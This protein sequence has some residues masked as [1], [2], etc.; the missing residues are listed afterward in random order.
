MAELLKKGGENLWRRIH[1]LIKLI[2]TRYQMP[3]EW[4]TGIIQPIYEKR[5][6]L[7]CSNYRAKTL[8]NVTYKVL[9]GILY[10]RLAEYAEEIL[11]DYQCGYRV[12]CSTIHQIFTIRQTQEKVYEYNLHLHKLFIDFNPLNA[13]LNPICHLLALLGARHILHISG[14]R[15][16]KAFDSVKRGRMLNNFLILGISK[17]LVQLISVTMACY[18][19]T[20]RVDNQCTPTFPI[21]NGVRQRDALSSVLFDLVLRAIL[22]KM[23]ITGHIGTKYTNNCA[24]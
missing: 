9:S 18:K 10:N 15:V 22:Q 12:N 21:T 4:S 7:K 20:V 19:A 6:K 11:G 5:D 24:R 2:W 13:E 14:V 1:H 17:K 8:L 16:K 3:E 23:N